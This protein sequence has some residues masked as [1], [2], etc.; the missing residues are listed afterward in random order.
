MGGTGHLTWIPVNSGGTK[1][2]MKMIRKMLMIA[3]AIA[4]PL[5]ATAAVT[6]GTA[7]VAGA[8]TLP[9]TC[10]LGS[11]VVTFGS[12]GLTQ[13]GTLTTATTGA[14]TVSATSLNCGSNGTGT[15]KTFN[16]T[17]ANTACAGANNPTSSCTGPTGYLVGYALSY[18]TTATVLWQEIPTLKFK[19][20]GVTYKDKATSSA[21]IEPG[22]TCGLSGSGFS[23]KGHLTAPAVY[24]NAPTKLSMCLDAD[25]GTGT[26]GSFITDISSEIAGTAPTMVIDSATL[27]STLSKLKIT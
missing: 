11:G 19:I 22:G 17:S 2:Q 1:E 3:A 23:V 14:Q 20:N 21:A 4:V 12:A 7:T 16:I 5:A 13:N 26:S 6:V 9:I 10:K 25:T 8:T 15:G 18:A 24:N 27:D